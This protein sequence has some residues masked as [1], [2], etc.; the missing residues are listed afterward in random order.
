ML[1]EATLLS[2]TSTCPLTIHQHSRTTRISHIVEEHN[3][4]KDLDRICN[5][6][7]PHKGSNSNNSNSKK[8]REQIIRGRGHLIPLKTKGLLSWGKTKGC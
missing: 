4:V 8:D 5:N 1:T 7:M 3:K 6:I 2:S